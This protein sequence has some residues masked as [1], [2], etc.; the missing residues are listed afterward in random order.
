MTQP[1]RRTKPHSPLS[2]VL[3]T[4]GAFSIIGLISFV[5]I[6][7]CVLLIPF[8]AMRIRAG[9]VYGKMVGRTV[10]WMGGVRPV[11]HF[12]E[13]KRDPNP[14]IYVCNHTSTLDMW[15]G[16][17][18][19]PMGGCGVAKKEIVLI[20]FFGQA[21]WL[22]GHL[23]LDRGNRDKAIAS[24]KKA[25]EV[26][27]AHKLSVWMWP[28]GTRSR[29]GRLKAM[30]KGFAYFAVATGLPIIPVVIHDADLL[31]PGRSFQLTPGDLQIEVLPPHDTGHWTADRIPEQIEE[32]WGLIQGALGPRQQGDPECLRAPSDAEG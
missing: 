7:L 23:L 17:W 22:S 1:E 12:R 11:V 26:V 25:N 18:L 9:N 32:V 10:L 27:K 28:E 3:R 5:Y 20:P 29:D 6:L 21:Y 8:R 15:V 2:F 30:K 4:I 13:G 16:M 24:L 19:C 31:W 14:A